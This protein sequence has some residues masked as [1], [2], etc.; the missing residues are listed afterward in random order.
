MNSRGHTIL[1]GGIGGDSHSVGLHILRQALSMNGYKVRYLGIQN[2]LEE[3]CQL[4]PMCNLVMIS[5][6]D[7]HTRYYLR[8]WPELRKI[9][10][11]QKS[12]WYLGG[13]LCIGDAGGYESYFLKMGFDRVFVKFTDVNTVLE[14]IERDLSGVEPM[15]DCSTLWERST[16]F[17]RSLSSTVADVLVDAT[18]FERARP[19]ILEGWKT[20]RTAKDLAANAEFLARQ[21]SFPRI[22]DRVNCGRLPMLIQPRSGVPVI[23]EQVKMFLALKG[24]GVRVLSYQVDSLTRNNDYSSAEEA[25]RDSRASAVS[26]INGFPII[27]H[28]VSGLRRII[29]EVRTPLQ[30][31]HSTRDPRL[32]AEISY[33]GGVTAF[34][35]GAIC[36]NIPYYKDYPLDQSIR[37]WQYVDRLTGLYYERFNIKL[38]RE[39]FGT[40]TA[41]LVPPCLA[42]AVCIIE[43]ILA[44]QQG[45]KCLSLG[46]AEQGHRIQD[47]AAVRVLGDMAREIITRSGYKD[48]QINTVFHQ[49][50]AA[51]PTDR[52][53]AEDLIYNSAITASLS[54]ATRVMVK[55]PAEAYKVPAL[56]D[57]LVGVRLAMCGAHDSTRV[58]IDE[59][60]VKEE[61]VIIRKEAQAI[62]DSIIL[63]G[64]GSIAEGVVSGFRKG[65][66]DIPFSPSIYNRGE[67]TTAR[68]CEGAVRF[69]STGNLQFDRE[70]REFHRDKMSA[71]RHAERII[72]SKQDYQLIERDVMQVARGHYDRWP[73][74]G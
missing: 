9:Y 57:N 19:E 36:Y 73:L 74:F 27:N 14:I 25:I 15:P 13:N 59:A 58:V 51:F 50:M 3:F 65:F 31:R 2:R 37:M 21:E 23:E 34:E 29:S 61:C 35:G 46:Y 22:Q 30:A 6:M 52:K 41:V 12:L 17:Q 43:S 72:S 68:D 44:I 63:C 42:I 8:E 18:L 40:L 7:G 33:A 69:I 45:V 38:D 10:P 56:E 53:R 11:K 26:T 1:L 55:T 66:I 49:H 39:F 60:R 62:L 48:I 64:R 47:I 24:L 4:A 32:L 20:G 67:V 71:R 28:G 5:S 54:M 16:T 70:L